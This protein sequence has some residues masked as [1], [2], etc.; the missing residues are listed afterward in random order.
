MNLK[1]IW[2]CIFIILKSLNFLFMDNVGDVYKKKLK[3]WGNA[4]MLS[5]IK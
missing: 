5:E 1:L 4:Y 2:N 3:I